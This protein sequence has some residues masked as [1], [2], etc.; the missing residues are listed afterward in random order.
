M[1]HEGFFTVDV[2][3]TAVALSVFV[4]ILGVYAQSRRMIAASANLTTATC[5]AEKQLACIKGNLPLLRGAA[6]HSLTWQDESDP[7]PLRKNG[8][9]FH[10]ETILSD[11]TPEYLKETRVCITWQEFGRQR[12]LEMS[13]LL[14]CGE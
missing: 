3:I 14:Y 11:L 9:E 6:K 8:T 13:T 12:H 1:R 7:P 5:L 2:L 10:V 4:A